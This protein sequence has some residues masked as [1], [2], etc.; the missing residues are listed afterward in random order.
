ME[1]C[2]FLN[3]TGRVFPI[4]G[5]VRISEASAGHLQNLIFEQAFLIFKK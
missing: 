2:T 5:K 1:S 3:S 4:G